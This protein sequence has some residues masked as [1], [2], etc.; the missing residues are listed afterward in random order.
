M[1]KKLVV[2]GL[3][4][5]GFKQLSEVADFLNHPNRYTAA[6]NEQAGGVTSSVHW[7][8][9]KKRSRGQSHG[10]RALEI[11]AAG[12]HNLIVGPPGSGK[13]MLARRLPEILPLSFAE[14]FEV[15]Q[16]YSVAGLKRGSLVS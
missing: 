12:G 10:R 15:T 14:A 2:Q 6:N 5:H 3:A 16:I 9:L 4:V 7:G 13:I 8:R 1:S 11:A